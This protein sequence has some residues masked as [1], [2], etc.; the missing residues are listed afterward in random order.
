MP[1]FSYLHPC[2]VSEGIAETTNTAEAQGLQ[3]ES[4][5]M[6]RGLKRPSGD[7]DPRRRGRKKKKV[8]GPPLPK[9]ALMQLNEIRPGLEYQFVSQAGPVHQPNFIMSVEVNGQQFQGMGPSKK[10]AKLHAA[11]QALA[12]FVQ[13]PNASEAHQALGMTVTSSGDFTSDS[14]DTA[15]KIFNNFDPSTGDPAKGTNGN[16]AAPSVTTPPQPQLSAPRTLATQPAGK[17]PVMILNEIR[18]GTKYDF[19]SEAGESHSK[20]FVMS[21]TVD[22]ETF[23]GSGR[24]KKLAKS[25]AAQAALQ[26]LFNLH[27]NAAP[28]GSVTPSRGHLTFT[29]CLLESLMWSHWKLISLI[30]EKVMDLNAEQGQPFLPA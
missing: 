16:T 1:C 22:G 8:P 24:N 25:R 27:F 12:S 26:K 15:G 20:N 3:D 23:E 11:E 17:N 10:K 18:P 21:V 19:V 13:F 7:N 6:D 5:D 4:V 9:N 30:D 2:H 14:A 28:G 29:F